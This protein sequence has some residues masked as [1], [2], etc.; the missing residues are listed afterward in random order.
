MNLTELN[1][2]NKNKNEEALKNMTPATLDTINNLQEKSKA[3]EESIKAEK[4]IN[5]TG[6]NFTNTNNIAYPQQNKKKYYITQDIK[7]LCKLINIVSAF[8]E[9]KPENKSNY[10]IVT[11]PVCSQNEAYIYKNNQG[12]II[13][14]RGNNCGVITSLWDYIKNLYGLCENKD[15]FVKIAELAGIELNLIGKYEEYPQEFRNKLSKASIIPLESNSLNSF[16]NNANE[17]LLKTLELLTI[18]EEKTGITADTVKDCKIGFSETHDMFV[19]PM[20]YLNNNIISVE[21]RLNSFIKYIDYKGRIQKVVRVK[22]TP[23]SLCKIN[24]PENYQNI[25]IIEGIKDGYTLYQYLKTLGIEQDYLILTPNHGVKSIPNL[26]INNPELF[27]DKKIILSLDRDKAAKDTIKAI[28]DKAELVFFEL[29]LT[30]PSQY[31]KDFNDWY[32]LD[33]NKNINLFEDDSRIRINHKSLLTRYIKKDTELDKLMPL[34]NINDEHKPYLK[35]LKTG[36]HEINNNYYDIKKGD[37]KKSKISDSEEIKET[38]DL[39]KFSYMRKSNFILEITRKIINNR[40]KSTFE[41]ECKVEIITHSEDKTTA[42]II[43]SQDEILDVKNISGILK[44]R[45]YH[46]HTLIDTQLKNII[47]KELKR[48]NVESHIFENPGQVNINDNKQNY[49]IYQNACIQIGSGNIF[50]ADKIGYINIDDNTEIALRPVKGFQAPVLNKITTDILNDPYLQDIK[51][52][53]CNINTTQCQF[54]A[55]ALFV[56]TMEAY[57]NTIEPFMILGTAILS[58]FVDFIFNKYSGYPIGFAG[59]ESQSG[60]SNLLNTIAG[61][62]GY[63]QNYLKSGNDTPKNILHVIEYYNK[64]PVLIQ[65]TGKQ[66]RDRIEDF[67]IKPVYDRTGRGLMKSGDEQD[68][69][70]VN[71]TL[72]VASNDIIHRNLQTSSRLVYTDWKKDNFNVPNAKKFNNIR[73]KYLSGLMQDILN[74]NPD[75]ILNLIDRNIKEIE[76]NNFNIDTRS[77]VNIAIAKTG[78]DILFTLTGFNPELF[79]NNDVF[80]SLESNYIEFLK[81]YADT[82]AL[83]D[84]FTE[85]I[86]IFEI[87]VRDSKLIY[88][89][90]WKFKDNGDLAINMGNDTVYNRYKEYFRKINENIKGIPD[91]KSIKNEA[92][93]QKFEE[94]VLKFNGKDARC[95][96]LNYDTCNDTMK[97]T[98]QNLKTFIKKDCSGL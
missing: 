24:N 97:N 80:K 7:E 43:L 62:Y 3:I 59:G 33:D 8:P 78:Y 75:D 13:C 25:I 47:L 44:T 23:N 10:Y 86:G 92:K 71:S 64:Q 91:I 16:V 2:I 68:L 56:N 88:N 35:Y 18:L 50:E 52:K 17:Y 73:D 46:I 81:N 83:K 87:L 89:Q 11:C 27:K 94:K 9:L 26:I 36:I 48:K 45:G 66:L 72:I 14:N 5:N 28:I 51:T 32:L 6:S 74:I 85:F 61:L 29:T 63:K 77:I 98:I 65:E 82:T 70:A 67:L 34:N 69:K 57:S 4:P 20:I 19:F 95:I 1:N 31:F 54:I 53:Y 30:G 41:V 55:S 49:W 12:Y 21:F 37:N 76:S 58:T 22:N 93:R 79:N 84:V 38:Q 90:D 60:K 42:P 39:Y 40:L 96:V 15:I